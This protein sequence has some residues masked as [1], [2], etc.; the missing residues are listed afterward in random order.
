M[1][2]AH[3][4]CGSL[5]SNPLL[6]PTCYGWLRQVPQAAELN[7]QAA[8]EIRMRISDYEEPVHPVRKSALTPFERDLWRVGMIAVDRMTVWPGLDAFRNT[9]S[10]T[11]I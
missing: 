4:P 9:A 1:R 6:Q 2:R 7:R 3:T 11:H 10:H 8:S 5:R